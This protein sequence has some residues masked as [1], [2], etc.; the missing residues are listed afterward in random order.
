MAREA[1][2][3]Q[4]SLAAALTLL[5]S[6]WAAAPYFRG[7]ALSEREKARLPFSMAGARSREV[8]LVTERQAQ[9]HFFAAEFRSWKAALAEKKAQLPS[10]A[11]AQMRAAVPEERAKGLLVSEAEPESAPAEDKRGKSP[12]F[13]AEPRSPKNA[14]EARASAR[15]QAAPAD[16]MA[17]A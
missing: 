6:A 8:A 5:E 10:T 4:E 3:V 16:L 17:L 11:G 13:Q 14:I 15:V 2:L 9:L 1:E 12:L 7:A